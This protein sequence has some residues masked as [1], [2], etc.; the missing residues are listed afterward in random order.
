MSPGKHLMLR[1]G[2]TEESAGGYEGYRNIVIEGGTWDANYGN[3]PDK[4]ADGGFVC[5]RIGHASNVEVKDV[6]F[7]NNLKSH[8]LE[9]GGVKNAKV[10]GCT[11]R[12]YW[13]E[14]DR[15]RSRRQS[16]LTH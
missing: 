6:T 12:G 15:R 14:F 5:F 8:F 10:T 11:F 1:L 2:N 16:R 4:E 3:L 7:L 9:L 13:E